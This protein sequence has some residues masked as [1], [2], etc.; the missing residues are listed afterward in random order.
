MYLHTRLIPTIVSNSIVSSIFYNS[1]IIY[2]CII[3]NQLTLLQLLLTL[4]CYN[5]QVGRTC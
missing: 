2:Y 3:T 4:H 1:N 5:K